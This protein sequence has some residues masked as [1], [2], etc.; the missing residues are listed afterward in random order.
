MTTLFN[1]PYKHLFL[2]SLLVYI[3]TAFFSNGYYHHDEHFQILEFCNYK[4]GNSSGIDL[5]WEFHKKIRPALQPTIAIIGVK[6]LNLLGI[7]NPFTYALIFRILT[8]ILFWFVLCKFCVFLINNFS[9]EK[10]KKIFLLLSFYLWFTP[11]INVRFSSENYSAITFLAAVYLTLHF[12]K[13]GPRKTLLKLVFAGILLGFSFFFRFQIAFAILGLGLWLLIINRMRWN[14]LLVLITSG[15]IAMAFC[16]Y[17]D[18]WFYGNLEFTPLNYFN[19]NIFENKA[20]NWGVHPWW[21]YFHLF[22]LQVIP[23]IS[24][25]LFAFFFAGLYKRPKNIFTW[26]IIPFLIAHF[27]VGHKEM[28]FMFPMVFSFLYL[29]ALGIDDFIEKH[30]YEKA[31]RVMF[32]MV[33]II[34]MPL[35]FAKMITPAQEA[36]NY[37]R[38]LYS[39]SSKQKTDLLCT[40]KDAYELVGCK[41]NFYKPQNLNSWVFKSDQEI[42]SYL[43]ENKPESVLLLERKLSVDHEFTNYYKENMYCLF[44]DWILK[45]N[46]N[47]WQSKARIWNISKL[48]KKSNPP[49]TDNITH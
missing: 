10:G 15:I 7:Y 46:F 22:I 47:N 48:Q 16:T 13:E 29:T 38:F 20:S 2:I 18:Y 11:S 45:F 42:S 1:S 12:I 40:E 14:Y 43:S 49:I 21:Y 28:R 27:M 36:I 31:G 35:L 17:L 4:L 41:V 30:K 19:A 24:I 34:N 6:F 23:P 25:F 37:Y 9:T 8:A 39:Y 3:I 26:C 33:V 32:L 5:P 44:P